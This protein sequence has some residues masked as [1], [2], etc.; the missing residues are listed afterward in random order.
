MFGFGLKFYIIGAVAAALLAGIGYLAWDYRNLAT[1][2]ERMKADIVRLV[3]NY[4]EQKKILELNNDALTA[5]DNSC[6]AAA[7]RYLEE[8]KFFEEL[9]KSDD[10]LTDA[11]NWATRPR[12]NN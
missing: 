8:Q 2:N 5:L 1:Q 9:R 7:R 12:T 4:Q 10:P 6:K 11:F 3:N